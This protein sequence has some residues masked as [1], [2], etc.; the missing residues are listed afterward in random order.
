MPQ[1]L[2]D[3]LFSLDGPRQGPAQSTSQYFSKPEGMKPSDE[4]RK[5]AV[6][7]I[8]G[9]PGSV[10]RRRGKI[11]AGALAAGLGLAG[12]SR[13]GREEEEQEQRY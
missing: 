6:N 2:R 1:E 3:I 4:I 12:I 11:G 13:M 5:R 7:K 9:E 10:R 8:V